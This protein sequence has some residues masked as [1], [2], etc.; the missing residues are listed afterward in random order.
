M[1][2]TT[3][4]MY[5]QILADAQKKASEKSQL[6]GN[7]TPQIT[8]TQ[9]QAAI[10]ASKP[11]PPP[12]VKP[13]IVATPELSN[14]TFADIMNSAPAEVKPQPTPAAQAADKKIIGEFTFIAY[15]A[16]SFALI[17]PTYPIK[18]KMSDFGGKWNRHLKVGAAWIFPVK[19]FYIVRSFI[20]RLQATA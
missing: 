11:T 6:N 10:P 16:A 15:S 17:G 9:K 20:E 5:A 2:E 14:T 4:K 7:N 13:V 8:A 19:K 18:S 1:T 3:K 12:A